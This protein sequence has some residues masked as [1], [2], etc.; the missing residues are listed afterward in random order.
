MTA[1]DYLHLRAEA[2]PYFLAST[3]A[4]H[5]RRRGLTAAAVAA[6]LGCDADTLAL[7]G[8]CRRPDTAGECGEVEARFGLTPG[9][10]AGI[11]GL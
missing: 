3:L 9:S 1:L 7:V 5:A 11:C 10:V 8:L 4:D 6:E 2:D